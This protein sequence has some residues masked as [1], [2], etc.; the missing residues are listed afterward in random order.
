LK[1]HRKHERF[2]R[3]LETEFRS[4]DKN[5]RAISSDFSL[6]GLF[7]RTNNAFRPGTPLEITVHLPDGSEARLKGI[8]RR[9]LKTFSI[10]LKNGMGIEITE[11]DR[12]YANFIKSYAGAVN[13][14]AASEAGPAPETGTTGKS[15][16][17]EF[18]IIQCPQCGV[19]NKI[20]KGKP[21]SSARCGKCST[22]LLPSPGKTERA[23][24]SDSPDFIV[25][26]CPQC[27][28]KNRVKREQIKFSIKCGKCSAPL[29]AA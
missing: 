27:K 14:P 8:V 19:K 11:S 24:A 20:S 3:R 15:D 21:A 12:N 1:A 7:I 6:T 10:A 9:A 16:A 26:Q 13:Y 29:K 4:E 23:P 22:E 28:A 17:P 2:V 25:I 18:T 5:H